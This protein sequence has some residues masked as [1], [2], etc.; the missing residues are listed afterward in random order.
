MKIPSSRQITGLI[1]VLA[2]GFSTAFAADENAPKTKR[3]MQNPNVGAPAPPTQMC[4]LMA[5]CVHQEELEMWPKPDMK[6]V[7]HR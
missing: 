4:L 5:L 3:V 7:V 6:I 1:I 2:I